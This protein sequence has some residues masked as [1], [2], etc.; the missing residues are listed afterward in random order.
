MIISNPPYLSQELYDSAEPEVKEY[1]PKQALLSG[2]AGMSDLKIIM[3][4]AFSFLKP[5]GYLVFETGTDQH[6]ELSNKLE[7]DSILSHSLC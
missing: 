4:Q 7:M 3:E 2:D 1:E 5:E 6:A